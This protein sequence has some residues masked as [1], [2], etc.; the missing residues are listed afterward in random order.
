[1]RLAVLTASVVAALLA[2]LALAGCGS[3]GYVD[4]GDRQAGKELFV[5]HCGSCH[6]LA[7]A[8]TRGTIGPNLD[9]GFRQSRANGFPD[10]TFTQV[11]RDQIQYP[12]EDPVTGVPGMP[13]IDETLPVCEE[14]QTE[15]CVENQDEAA[16]SIAVYV[17]SVAGLEPA[18]GA[19]PPPAPPPPPPPGTTEPPPPPGT[20]EP[21][22]PP[23]GGGLAEGKRVFESAGCGSCHTLADAGTTGTIGPNLDEAQPSKELAVDRVTNGRGAMPPFAGQL[24]EAEIDAVATYVS[25]VA[26]R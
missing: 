5:S 10:E 4:E 3:V 9:D 18:G 21:P 2:L 11:V 25:T 16:D 12:I 22:P 7:D 1:V 20:T 23:P 6:V 14:G 15:R 19:Q 26:G 17:A 24:S 8:G 13:G